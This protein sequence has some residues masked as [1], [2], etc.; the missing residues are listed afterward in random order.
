VPTKRRG[1]HPAMPWPRYR[2]L[3]FRTSPSLSSV[4]Y[5]QTPSRRSNATHRTARLDSVEPALAELHAAWSYVFVSF[6][7][8]NSAPGLDR[9]L[10]AASS[11][12][13]FIPVGVIPS[14]LHSFLS[15]FRDLF[16]F[17]PR[18]S[19]LLVLPN[20]TRTLEQ[21]PYAAGWPA[22]PAR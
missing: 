3:Q 16:R 10:A 17:L 9:G 21:V 6:S 4:L 7:R 22:W 13:E 12:S 2:C 15:L 5:I 11:H 14:N 18:H 19:R 1:P 8:S 20:A